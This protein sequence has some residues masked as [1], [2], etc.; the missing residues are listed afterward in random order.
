LDW[1]LGISMLRIFLDASWKV[2]LHGD[3]TQAPE[4][5]DW[6]ATAW[7]SAEDIAALSPDLYDVVPAGRQRLPSIQAR[8]S[9]RRFVVVHPFWARAA[10]LKSAEDDFH[11]TTLL[12]DTFQAVRRPQ[13][14][15]EY[16]QRLG[17][18]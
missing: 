3:W 17:W 11:G 13:A 12:I 8:N 5:A 9:A 2:G 14:A 7:R 1:R 10:A 18:I 15:Q 6:Q 16:A 4:L